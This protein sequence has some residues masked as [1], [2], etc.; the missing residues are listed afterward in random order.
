M[1][2][3]DLSTQRGEVLSYMKCKSQL[4]KMRWSGV[5]ILLSLYSASLWAF[6]IDDVAKQAKSLAGKRYEAPKS[7]LPVVF[8]DM[9]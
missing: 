9:K 5:A 1:E 4:L 2:Q 6:T 8:R 7:N 3:I